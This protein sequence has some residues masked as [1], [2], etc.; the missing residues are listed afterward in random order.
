MAPILTAMHTGEPNLLRVCL[1]VPITLNRV[2]ERG[3]RRTF[4]WLD[5]KKMRG[6]FDSV[7]VEGDG[8]AERLNNLVRGDE[9]KGVAG[10][11]D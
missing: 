2:L 3:V 4:G 10:Q 8:M 11:A 6:E 5:L 1:C 7:F 9:W